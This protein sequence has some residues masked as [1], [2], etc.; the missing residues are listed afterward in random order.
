MGI[1][2]GTAFCKKSMA[3]KAK[4]GETSPIMAT[5]PDRKFKSYMKPVAKRVTIQKPERKNSVTPTEILADGFT[6]I[7]DSKIRKVYR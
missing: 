6:R 7:S 5:R 4:L 3:Q 1:G 2:A